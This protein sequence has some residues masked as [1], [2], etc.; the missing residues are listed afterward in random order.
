LFA[1]VIGLAKALEDHA[2]TYFGN[3]ARP[4]VILESDNPIPVE[5]AE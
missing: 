3:G 1:N 4:G 5:A 2:S